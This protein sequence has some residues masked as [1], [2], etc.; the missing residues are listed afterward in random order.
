MAH[1]MTPE[2]SDTS[3]NS[4]NPQEN[5]VTESVFKERLMASA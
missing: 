1:S 2:N 5:T 4:Q 3:G